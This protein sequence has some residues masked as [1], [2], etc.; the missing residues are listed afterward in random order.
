MKKILSFILHIFL[1]ILG[2]LCAWMAILFFISYAIQH[3]GLTIQPKSFLVI[4]WSLGI[5]EVPQEEPSLVQSILNEFDFFS[6]A[7]HAQ[8]SPSIWDLHTALA[9]AALDE[10]IAGILMIGSVSASNMGLARIHEAREAI[11]RFQASGKP[12]YGFIQAGTISDYYM[13]SAADQLWMQP[14]GFLIFA[15]LAAEN[16]FLKDAFERYGIGLQQV[17]EGKYKSALEMFTHN[18]L[19]PENKEEQQTLIDDF[20][21]QIITDISQSR[22]QDI[23][24]LN[25]IAIHNP[26]VSDQDA[27]SYRLIDDMLYFDEVIDRLIQ[28]GQQ[29]QGSHT[30]EQVSLMDYAQACRQDKNQLPIQQIAIVYASGTI[31]DGEGTPSQMGGDRLARALRTLRYDENIKGIVLRVDSPGGSALASEVIAREVQ[32]CSQSKPLSVC[33]GDYAA[34]G[35]YW[36]SCLAP[37]IWADPMT[38]TGS[39]GVFSAIPNIQKLANDHGVYFDGVQTAPHAGFLSQYTQPRTQSQLDFI[40]K[41]TQ[42]T[43]QD[44]LERVALGRHL[45]IEQTQAIAQGRIWSGIQAKNNHLIDDYGSLKQAVDDI[46]QQLHIDEYRIAHITPH[47]SWVDEL[48]SYQQNWW[49]FTELIQKRWAIQPSYLQQSQITPVMI[50]D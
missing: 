22:Q 32:L 7:L 4:D 46:A 33:F 36:I 2:G 20:W 3:K 41:F 50:T 37:K 14:Q 29:K 27:Q 48:K 17:K 40:Q 39:I 6:Q 49:P 24:V 15:G 42:N 23:S 9:Q 13:L 28:N 21:T 38:I 19:S 8:A 26:L 18:Q 30:F 5:Q 11:K 44:F 35:G 31:V 43:Y 34:S 12:I 45:S 47:Y 10:R 1:S 16:I 25:A